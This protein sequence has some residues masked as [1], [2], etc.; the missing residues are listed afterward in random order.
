MRIGGIWNWL[1]STQTPSTLIDIQNR[2]EPTC[3]FWAL[4]A[5]DDKTVPPDRNPLGMSLNPGDQPWYRLSGRAG[6]VLK[7]R[8]VFCQGRKWAA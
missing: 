7:D 4:E 5:R 2:A 6:R 3:V 1:A 8:Q